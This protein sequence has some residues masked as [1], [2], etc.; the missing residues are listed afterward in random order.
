V[1][2]DA[3]SL[4]KYLDSLMSIESVNIRGSMRTIRKRRK[5]RKQGRGRASA[6]VAV[7]CLGLIASACGSS[8]SKSS[9]TSA[10]GTSGSGSSTTAGSSA[11][12]SGGSSSSGGGVALKIG[13]F[14]NIT[15]AP[16]LVGVQDGIFAKALSPDTLAKPQIFSAGPA[17][18]QALLSGSIDIAFEG[19]SS[20]L[21]AYSSSHAVTIIAGVASGGAGLVVNKSITSAS[22]LKG[23]K[24]GSPQLA[25]TQDIAL[26]YWLKTKGYTTT[27]TGGGDVSVVPSATGSGTV[28]TEFESGAIQGAWMAE[29]YEQ[30]LVAAG[31]HILVPEASLWPS[32]QWATT[33]LVVSTKFLKAHPATVSRF[34][35]GLLNTLSYMKA[36]KAGAEAAANK[37]IDSLSGK[38]LKSS[39]LSASWANIT[40]TDDPL[41]STLETQIKHGEAVGLLKSPGSLSAIYDLAPLNALLSKA[42]DPEV[43][44]L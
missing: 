40:F 39:V 34:L 22:Q 26:R 15:H 18:N 37:Q 23:K 19:P 9:G 13:Y 17:E 8:S 44:G 41:A 42:G 1:I 31:G 3:P 11:T 24:L 10:S 32:G 5:T 35:Q 33:N 20:A 29:P 2:F 14:P 16:A 28:V 43:K 7:A 25:N 36:N 38:A 30:E 4:V 12:T 6:L 27:S 21:S